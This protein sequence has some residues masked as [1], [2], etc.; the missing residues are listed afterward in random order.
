[1]MFKDRKQMHEALRLLLAQVALERL[2]TDEGPTP[3]A[4]AH[5]LHHA[6][7]GVQIADGPRLS[8]GE[9]EVL[10][11]AFD[12]FNGMGDAK[13]ADLICNLDVARQRAVF[14][15]LAAVAM[16]DVASWLRTMAP[17]PRPAVPP[18]EHPAEGCDH[19]DD[20]PCECA[21]CLEAF[22]REVAPTSSFAGID[23][24]VQEKPTT[25]EEALR[26]PAAFVDS[27]RELRVV[28]ESEEDVVNRKHE[29]CGRTDE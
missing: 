18:C 27:F 10:R 17:M 7:L 12:V 5:L 20:C 15:L 6:G 4:R 2:W 11:V 14:T 28:P 21:E 22:G 9:V 1:M 3:E 26:D 24:A 16:G 19:P 25:I 23:R 29:E 8:R 13:V